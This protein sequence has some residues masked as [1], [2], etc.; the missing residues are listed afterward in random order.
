MAS[1]QA[2]SAPAPQLR[3]G[4]AVRDITPTPDMLPLTRAPDVQMTGVLDPIHVRVIALSSGAATTLIVCAET[5]RSLGPQLARE[6]SRHVGIPLAA[7]LFT[8]THSHATPEVNETWTNLAIEERLA[9]TGSERA[10]APPVTAQER[11]VAYAQQQLLA[12]A[13]EAL[14][15]MQDAS[16]GIGYAE[17]YINVNRNSP[18]NKTVDGKV[19]EYM[20]LGYNPTGPSD[21]TVVAIRFN[22]A[23]GKPL[24]FVINYAVHGTV[25][26]ANTN[27]D[28]K[29]GISSDIPGMIST[30]LE[31]KYPGSVAVW[32]SGA[33]GD[34]APLFQ[35][36]MFTR[37]P[38]TGE[39]DVSFSNSYDLLKYLSRIHFADV[40]T[41]L[42]RITRYE[43]AVAVNYDYRDGNIPGKKGGDY[44]VSLQLLRIGDI[45]LIGFPG[46]LFSTL[47]KAIK[48][49][50]PLKNTIV[51]NHAWQR[52]YQHPGYHADDAALAR[53]GFGTNGDY[54]P[55]H[56]EPL[57][58]QLTR[59]MIHETDQWTFRGDGTASNR[60]GQRVIVGRDGIAGSADDDEIL[61]PAGVVLRQHVSVALDS[62]GHAYVPLGNGFNLYPGQSHDLGGTDAV[63]AGFGHYP[64]SDASGAHADPLSW[65]L[66]DIQGEKAVLATSVQLDAL[67]FNPHASDGNDYVTSNLRSWL[68][69]R[70]GLDLRG[71]GAGFYNVAFSED[72]KRKIVPTRLD[73]AQGPPFQTVN[74][75]FDHNDRH[76]PAMPIEDKVWALSGEEVVRYFGSSNPIT[77]PS[78]DGSV[79]TT[80]NIYPSAY[81]RARGMKINLGGNGP[82]LVGY[83]DSWLRTPGPVDGDK[84]YGIFISS[85]GNL[86]GHRL[87]DGIYG[88][89]PAIT[90]SLSGADTQPAPKP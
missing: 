65:R 6:L 88:A 70:G 17:S 27:L 54:L 57:L 30:F 37:N 46:E 12:A 48:Q 59:S 85:V 1:A 67:Q 21:K 79:F 13:D 34:Q 58:V 63:I 89:L 74:P 90:V 2:A 8:S 76:T 23:A 39:A 38:L 52:P 75:E 49:G 11:W 43:H 60:R 56:L 64:Q 26:H 55:G 80:A 45:A 40:E 51:V 81:A 87:V 35:N 5:G 28:G 31:Q 16:V 68:N 20:A 61:S 18:Y 77:G 9:A 24:A 50:S 3:I 72:E 73:G 83:G 33:A 22:D 7:I 42:S 78:W 10:R 41:A 62:D 25:M 71:D 44:S 86:N 36:Q 66:L 19:I 14:G 82:A 84:Y 69:S 32:L 47:G 29:T 53:G 4:A 15:H